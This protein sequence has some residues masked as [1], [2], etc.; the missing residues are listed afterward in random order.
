[1]LKK[2][3]IIL[4]IIVIFGFIWSFFDKSSTYSE[5]HESKP[6]IEKVPE[7]PADPYG[8][9]I[10]PGEY[11]VLA[12]GEIKSWPCPVG[13]KV[14]WNN[15]TDMTSIKQLTRD[16]DPKITLQVTGS[17]PVRVLIRYY[18]LPGWP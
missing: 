2:S 18:K 14:V 11:F 7:L 9:L 12:P 13:S 16:N 1:M 10:K 17:K 3:I 6:N 4:V 8:E 15:V 5:S